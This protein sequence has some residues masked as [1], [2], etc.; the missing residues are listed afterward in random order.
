MEFG[1][2]FFQALKVMENLCFDKRV[3]E[4]HGITKFMEIVLF[5]CQICK[6]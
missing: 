4:S 1:L 6:K 2:V 5:F 3:M